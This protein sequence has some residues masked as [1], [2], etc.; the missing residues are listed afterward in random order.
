MKTI[1]LLAVLEASNISGPAK[2]LL[3]FASM[4]RADRFSPPVDVS[5][6]TFRRSG[7]SDLFA[8]KCRELQIPLHIIPERSRFDRTTIDRLAKLA[9][10]L[11]PDVIQTHAV[12]SHFLLR[13]A[14]LDR[15]FPWVAFHHGYT[16]EDLR[17]RMYN[18]LDRWSLRAARRVVTVSIPFREELIR[19]GVR[20]ERIQIVHNA[21]DPQYGAT[22]PSAAADLR[23]KLG[24]QNGTP[25][26][27][28][29]GRMSSEKDHI[30]LLEAFQRVHAGIIDPHLVI[31]GEGPERSKIEQRIRT[32]DL[33]S[34]VTL[35]GHVS[36]AEPYYGIASVAVLSSRSEGS[37]NALLESMAAR[38]PTVATSVG[39]VPEIVAHRESALLAAPGNPDELA[40][41]I[42]EILNSP[43]FAAGL[44][45][46]AR[47][48]VEERH[49][50]NSRTSALCTL[51]GEV[52]RPV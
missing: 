6:A 14:G 30:C 13:K 28:S 46:R 36:S 8:D 45:E 34:R 4:A 33:A 3:Q 41:A 49:S 29:V 2:N 21:I 10:T 50:P 22:F 23:A 48:L 1:R 47:L 31:V 17:V 38:V 37:P 32:L 15:A 11:A 44:V 25:V 52:L 43:A 7:D 19:H 27:L 39:G 5:I 35:T 40:R 16:W 42:S 20:Q 12:K 9:H 18:Q 26:I 51:Y 24:L